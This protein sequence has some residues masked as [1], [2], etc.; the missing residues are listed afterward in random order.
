LGA[1]VHARTT[2]VAD[3]QS[4]QALADEVHA[5]GGALDV[6]INNA[7]V[8]TAGKLIE[9]DF[10]VWDW[11]LGVNVKGVVHGCRL[12]GPARVERGQGGHFVNVASAAG[13]L[14]P[15]GMSVYAAT[16]FAVVGLSEALR[17]ELAE[18][19]IEV[20]TLCPGVVDTPIVRNSRLSGSLAERPGFTD[21][22]AAFYRRRGY[23]P[24][25]VAQVVLRAV[26]EGRGGVL[27]VTPEAWG[28]YFAKR[29]VP[30]LANLFSARSAVV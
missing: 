24:E 26:E 29:F 13:L 28:L 10:A 1:K 21:R 19:R 12:F 6:L 9:T 4:V 30:E 7:G 11:A 15:R 23:G 20:T 18:H 2:D 25:R 17:A 22:I 5:Q 8:G 27:P 3:A 14:A 16:K